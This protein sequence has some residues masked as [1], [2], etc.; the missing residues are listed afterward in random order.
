MSEVASAPLS[1]ESN[2][3]AAALRLRH[4]DHYIPM[5][6]KQ[7]IA[8]LPVTG[9][10]AKSQLFQF[11]RVLSALIHYNYFHTLEAL[12]ELYTPF[13]PEGETGARPDAKHLAGMRADFYTEF[14]RV[15]DGC[16]F[17]RIPMEIINKEHAKKHRLKGRLLP[18]FD[19]YT[20]VRVF[21]RGRTTAT[22]R[23]WRWSS[24]WF[25]DHTT[26]MASHIVIVA[27][28]KQSAAAYAS[29]SHDASNAPPGSIIVKYFR[30][31]PLED[32]QMLFPKVTAHM[33]PVEKLLMWGPALLGAGFVVTNAVP[34]VATLAVVGGYYVGTHTNVP[35]QT[36]ANMATASAAVFAVIALIVRQRLRFHARVLRYHKD[37]TDK[38]YFKNIS[39]NAG[40]FDY[41]VGQAEEQD[42]KEVLLAYTFLLA[43]PEGLREIEIDDLVE[44][45]LKA[46][47]NEDIDFDVKDAVLKL[48]DLK[49]VD[50]DHGILRATS[51]EEALR[52]M[53]YRWDNIFQYNVPQA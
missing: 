43:N 30:N 40:I 39:N 10:Q 27:P 41:L 6:K 49:L 52:R 44:H 46:N 13:N 15:L 35:S 23:K 22:E 21:V 32:I 36:F 31:I 45:W 16:N 9:K 24:L 48:K 12:R 42:T 19:S 2:Y 37:I 47:F 50:S 20:D 11:Q 17:E 26:E 18:D 38:C 34:A 51:V 3:A 14:V 8:K 29:G 53:D 1:P 4:R 5:T 28:V 25:R 7:L 33:S